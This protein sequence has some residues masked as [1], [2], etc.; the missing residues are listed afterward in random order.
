MQQ[1]IRAFTFAGLL[2][3]LVAAGALLAL[4]VRPSIPTRSADARTASIPIATTVGTDTGASALV[5]AA[6]TTNMYLVPDRSSE[7]VAILPAGQHASVDGRTADLAWLHV[8][9]PPGSGM[10]GWVRAAAIQPNEALG[11]LRILTSD[12][13]VASYVLAGD[14]R[15][16]PDPALS[17]VFLIEGRRLALGIRNLGQ[18]SM[19]D[20]TIT[21]SVTRAEGEVVSVLR[22]GPTTLAP[23]ASVTVVTPLEITQP[24]SYRLEIDPAREIADAQPANNIRQALLV[25][26]RS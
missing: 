4:A 11:A 20:V 21:L 2:V 22:I 15:R 16:L 7:V 26:T 6:A 3:V 8:S 24:G 13:D 5:Q 12:I 19:T 25:P 14:A 9:Y 23:G 10:K 18:G 17:D 1:S